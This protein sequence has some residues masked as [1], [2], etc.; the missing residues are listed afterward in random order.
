MAEDVYAVP[1]QRRQAVNDFPWS[2][3]ENCVAERYNPGSLSVRSFGL[4][5]YFAQ[6]KDVFTFDANEEY[7]GAWEIWW[8]WYD[9]F[10]ASR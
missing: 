3:F 2:D 9:E 4:A 1:E 5:Q 6:G 7:P 8:T 10:A